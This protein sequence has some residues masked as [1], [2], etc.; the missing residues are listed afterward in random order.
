MAI[1]KEKRFWTFDLGG[2]CV[3]NHQKD[4]LK[5]LKKLD[6][7]VVERNFQNIWAIKRINKNGIFFA[8]DNSFYLWSVFSRVVLFKFLKRS[9]AR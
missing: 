7:T 6:L 4:L 9:L 1:E 3:N 5:L 8:K 2:E